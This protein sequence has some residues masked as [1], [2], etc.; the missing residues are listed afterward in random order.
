MGHPLRH[1]YTPFLTV[2]AK[3]GLRL[4]E[5]LGLDWSDVELV[6]GAGAINVLRH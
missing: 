2:A 6:K 4:G 1:D 5:G 3:A